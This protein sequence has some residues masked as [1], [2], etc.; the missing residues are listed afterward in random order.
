MAKFVKVILLLLLAFALNGAVSNLCSTGVE[1]RENAVASPL[2]RLDK[3]GK[4]ELPYLPIAELN[5]SYLQTNQFSMTRI[6]R[7]QLGEY[8]YS[9]KSVFL[10]CSDREASLSRHQRRIYNTKV[11]FN[12]QPSSEY[13][14]FALRHIII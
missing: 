1:Q 13:Y 9:L 14:V 5:G 2:S 8:F 10:G 7:V 3:I 4:P 6:Q 12:S 11:I